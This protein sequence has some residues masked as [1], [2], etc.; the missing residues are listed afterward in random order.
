MERF[1][2]LQVKWFSRNSIHAKMA[3][4]ALLGGLALLAVGLIGIG[5]MRFSAHK[6]REVHAAESLLRQVMEQEHMHLDGTL[7]YGEYLRNA[8]PA[9][10]L[11][12]TVDALFRCDFSEQLPGASPDLPPRLATG[13]AAAQSLA[14]AHT[15]FH[16]AAKVIQDE[17]QNT[18]SPAAAL[19]AYHDLLI[20][21]LAAMEHETKEVMAALSHAAADAR[22]EVERRNTRAEGLIILF[23]LLTTT[24]T[25]GAGLL[26]SRYLSKRVRGLADFLQSMAEGDSDL[27]RRLPMRRLN[28]S[29]IRQC[30]EMQCPEFGR[31]ASCW[32]TVGSNAPG[33]VHCKTILSGKLQGCHQCPVVQIAARDELDVLTYWFN[34]FIGRLSQLIQRTKESL[35][36]M[37][38]ASE[39]LKEMASTLAENAARLSEEIKRAEV[40][41]T[42]ASGK[43]DAV[44]AAAL[45]V[46]DAISFL[47]TT[48]EESKQGLDSLS[49][50]VGEMTA[51][52]ADIAHNTEQAH[53]ESRRAVD[54]VEKAA[55]RIFAHQA[56]TA[57]IDQVTDVIFEIAEQTKLLAL[58]AT[59]EA[60]RAGEAGKGFAV[61]ATEVKELAK[62]T[63]SATVDIRQRLDTMHSSTAATAAEI[64]TISK[65]IHQVNSLVSSIAAVVEEQSIVIRDIAGRITGEVE[66]LSRRS[67][68]MQLAM[69]D[70]ESVSRAVA[71]V[72]EISQQLALA[73]QQMQHTT[74]DILESGRQ[75]VDQSRSLIHEEN[76][77][78]NMIDGFKT[79]PGNG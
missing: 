73:L 12:P 1:T 78:K 52:V 70:V 67:D 35:Q 57:E 49:L 75:T 37:D 74:S 34:N 10:P 13:E 51:T 31:A 39:Q 28:C 15:A 29:S 3:S 44:T 63:N 72:T 46:N 55:E 48:L 58:N 71:E 17:L 47:S 68:A 59:I 79:T 77:L 36:G 61:V 11:P 43:T 60:A 62:Q 76:E 65:V 66:E 23:V 20:P 42:T 19:A 30:N 14:T 33:K 41:S 53:T 25:M 21:R 54:S 38:L 16:E 8:D 69:S 50:T 2:E 24:L 27:S 5:G 4:G 56:T 64:E 40:T 26:Y 45:S 22:Q 6:F 7:A 9:L 18:G 32:D